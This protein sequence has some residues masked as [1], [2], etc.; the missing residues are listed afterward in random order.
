MRYIDGFVIPVPLAKKDAYRA[1]AAKTAPIFKEHGALRIVE[2][3]ADDVPHGQQTDFYRAVQAR[4]DETLV[5]SWIEWPSKEV[6]D[7]GNAKAMA[8]PRMAID[9]ADLPLDGKR[10][11]LGGFTTLLDE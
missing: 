11:V 2:C 5:F 10:M 3:W 6:R 4:E 1:F 8:D 7:A 9:L